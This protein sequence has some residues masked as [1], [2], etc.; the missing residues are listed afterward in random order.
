VSVRLSVCL[1]RRSI[2]AIDRDL[3][4]SE[5]SSGQRLTL[6]S[7]GRGSTE[8][9]TKRQN[10]ATDVNKTRRVWQELTVTMVEY[11]RVATA[12]RGCL[13]A[14]HARK[15]REATVSQLIF[16]RSVFFCSGPKPGGTPPE[17][18]TL[19]RVKQSSTSPCQH[20]TQST[21][22]RLSCGRFWKKWIALRN[23]E[24]LLG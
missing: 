2:A 24:K 5:S 4:A 9:N 10:R 11:R 7:E 8:T 19:T 21:S 1:S 3:T 20:V 17:P 22:W 16:S 23:G 12:G 18:T 13:F 6:R 15:K 14:R